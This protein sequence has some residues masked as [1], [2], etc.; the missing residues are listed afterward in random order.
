MAQ[1]FSHL[2][3]FSLVQVFFLALCSAYPYFMNPDY[4]L[5]EVARPV[6]MQLTK[7]ALD[8]LESNDFGLFKRALSKRSFDRADTF[9]AECLPERSK[10]EEL[11]NQI[12]SE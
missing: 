1:Y 12:D 2:L 9:A 5:L 3:R 8:R 6:P 10:H 11:C 7:R 4:E